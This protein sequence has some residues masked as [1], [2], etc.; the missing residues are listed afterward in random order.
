MA[1]PVIA[2]TGTAGS[3]TATSASVAIPAVSTGDLIVILLYIESTAAAP[4]LTNYSLL[5]AARPTSGTNICAVHAVWRRAPANASATSITWSGFASGPFKRWV[6]L[7][8]TGGPATDPPYE[9]ATGSATN[10]AATSTPTLALTTGGP[11]RLGIFVGGSFQ[12]A[13][14]TA[15]DAFTKLSP[16]SGTSE[17]SWSS[18][19]VDTAQ[20]LSGLTVNTGVGDGKAALV[21]AIKTAAVAPTVGAGTDA[22][23]DQY[24]T[25]SR[26]ATE[27]DGGGTI[28]A[29]AWT[30]VS[31]PNQVG[32]TIGTAAALSWAPTVGGTYVL[33][34]SATNSAGTGTDDVQVTVNP[35]NFPVTAPLRL[36]AARAGAKQVTATPTA[37]LHLGAD[38]GTPAKQVTS[39]RTAPIHLAAAATGLK[40]NLV[41]APIRLAAALSNAGSSQQAFVTATLRLA[42]A[43][44]NR[45]HNTVGGP[46]TAPL[47]LDA[48]A[49]VTSARSGAVTADLVLVADSDGAKHMAAPVAGHLVLAAAI[50]G[51]VHATAVQRTALI[52]IAATAGGRFHTAAAAVTAVMRLHTATTTSSVR[53]N[54]AVSATI[55]LHAVV[56]G[57]RIVAEVFAVRPRADTTV[58]YELVAVA[59][60]PQVAGPPLFLEVDP[61]NWTDLTWSE[62]LKAAPTLSATVKIDSLTEP[63]LQRLRTP[64]DSPTELWLN[65][66]GRRV[67]AGPLLGGRVSGGDSLSLEA[68][69]I[70]TY[71]RWMHVVANMTFTSID[72]NT[73]VAALIDQWQV[74]DYG[75]FGLDTSQVGASGVLRTLSYP[76]TELHKVADRIDDLAKLADGFDW[77]I[78][79]TSRQLQMYSPTRGQDRSTGED[80]IIFDQRNITSSDITFSVAPADLASDGLGTGTAS[81][82]D[83]PLVSTFSNAELRARFGRTGIVG[84]FQ[85]D[86][87]AAL[88]AAVQ[89][90]VQARG[91]VL[92]I[93]GPSARVTLDADIADY[94]PGDTIGYQAHAR[95]SATG[96]WRIRKRTIS[97]ASTGTESV[98]VEF[99]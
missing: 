2:A 21:F 81:G 76:Y 99:V 62:E 71:L 79:P 15:P 34:Y 86:N 57:Q 85:T 83:A 49:A 67:F 88:D 11:D 51:V 24:A 16:T 50:G 7:R 54:R 78:D 63:I 68:S 13:A 80:A 55:R 59:R 19:T 22:T 25:F 45:A 52:R 35:L 66:N 23:I 47:A 60:V 33:R 84:T 97:V 77:A 39:A 18:R 73:I 53:F 40:I 56:F 65:R 9:G 61:I 43:A 48:A 14:W 32:A 10:A 46:V 87:Q 4:S 92:L 96:A 38:D 8:I 5:V 30:V 36:F 26:T 93:P 28:T 70:Q 82:S 69:G 20:T 64:A 94:D 3:G 41:V 95:L 75:H 1:A 72:Q 29:R 6:A 89:A 98:A 58:K 42:A 90:M 74:Q 27:N 12:P 37:A 17:L 91:T 44:G 31:G